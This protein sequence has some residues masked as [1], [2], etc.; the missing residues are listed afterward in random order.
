MRATGREGLVAERAQ[1]APERQAS[2][3]AGPVS[4][5]LSD[6]GRAAL[7]IASAAVLALALVNWLQF[8]WVVLHG[9]FGQYDFSSYYA[10]AAA[11]RANPHTDIYSSAVMARFGA[12]GH[13]QVQPPLPYTY[14][15]LLAIALV[16]LTLLP[17]H[18]AARLWVVGNA[19]L[20]LL[21]ALILAHELRHLLGKGLAV[22]GRTSTEGSARPTAWAEAV[23]DP[24]GI[25]ALAAA[26]ALCLPFAPAVQTLLTGQMN[27]LVLLPLA[28]VPWLTRG[29]QEHWVGVAVA[30]TAMLKFTPALLLVYLALRRRWEALV[31]A[32]VALAALAVVSMAVVG[33]GVFFA[34]IPEAL[35]VG[36]GDAGL[37]HNE[38]LLAPVIAALTQAAPGW[39]PA[40]RVVEYALLAGLAI[41]V[42]WV[43][44]RAWRPGAT[45]DPARA[46]DDE[47]A[48]YALALC[49]LVLL[50]PAVWVHH[51]VWI[52]PAAA[53]LLGLTGRALIWAASAAERRTAGTRLGLIVVAALLLG[54]MLPYNW[55]TEPTPATTTVFGLPLRPLLL[56]FRAIGAL[57]LALIAAM[58]LLWRPG[59]ASA[60]SKDDLQ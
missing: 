46:W 54:W 18:V 13:V 43:L 6:R 47:S 33:P 38:A 19:G 40:M 53:L 8:L 30:V 14:P 23:A 24:S 59:S 28:A 5:R 15:P 45:A 16:P 50:S 35:H 1:A 60:E 49:A 29:R 20:W 9:P 57:M 51:Y 21:C 12:A 41:A 27:F 7:V 48:A 2:Q 52:L 31:A 4:L 34:A 55:D 32:V 17:F 39:G 22:V 11:L 10:A 26:G 58:L 56:E 25:V 42:G 3:A 37:G 36:G 44:W